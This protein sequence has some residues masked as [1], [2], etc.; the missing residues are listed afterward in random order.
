MCFFKS[1]LVITF[2]RYINISLQTQKVKKKSQNC[3]NQGSSYFFCWLMEG[4]WYVQIIIISGSESGSGRTGKI[5]GNYGSES[6]STILFSMAFLWPTYTSRVSKSHLPAPLVCNE[7][8]IFSLLYNVLYSWKCPPEPVD[9]AQLRPQTWVKS[10]R[11]R[12]NSF[13]IG[14]QL[15]FLPFNP[16]RRNSYRQKD[17]WGGHKITTWTDIS[18]IK[19]ACKVGLKRGQAWEV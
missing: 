12:T 3:R 17:N 1:F 15:T 6:R 14:G 4:S 16:T 2:R 18:A 9:V 19:I 7:W 5:Y 10:K 13:F 8:L 11:K